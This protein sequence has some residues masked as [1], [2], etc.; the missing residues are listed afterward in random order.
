MANFKPD[1]V[2]EILRV[3]KGGMVEDEEIGERSKDEVEYETEKPT[4][5]V[6]KAL[7]IVTRRE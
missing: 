4:R 6:R 5:D 3:S 7:Q 2:F 1:L